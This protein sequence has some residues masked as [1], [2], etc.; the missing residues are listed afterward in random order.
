MLGFPGKSLSTTFRAMACICRADSARCIKVLATGAS[1]HRGDERFESFDVVYFRALGE[2]ILGLPSDG[3]VSIVDL[4]VPNQ[5][6]DIYGG[7]SPD[8][9][10]RFV[11]SRSTSRQGSE[12]ID[13]GDLSFGFGCQQAP[14]DVFSPFGSYFSPTFLVGEEVVCG[15]DDVESGEDGIPVY[16]ED[17]ARLCITRAEFDAALR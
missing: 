9:I 3:R 7:V 11:P 5:N 15:F 16:P 17:R 1:L 13:L 8:I 2:N 4:N 6:V 14:P 10:S 12:P